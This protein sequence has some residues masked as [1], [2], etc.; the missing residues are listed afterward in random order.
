M[1]CALCRCRLVC[2]EGRPVVLPRSSHRAPLLPSLPCL[3]FMSCFLGSGE[4][5]LLD[6]A[7]QRLPLI[8][9]N[10]WVGFHVVSKQVSRPQ[11]S[12]PPW[13]VGD[14]PHPWK[15][16]LTLGDPLDGCRQGPGFSGLCCLCAGVIRGSWAYF[17]KEG[18]SLGL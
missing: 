4:F 3:K 2:V 7:R 16:M 5:L 9:G 11:A 17:Q 13:V 1:A 6:F 18:P 15:A 12:C 14:H 10:P 8:W